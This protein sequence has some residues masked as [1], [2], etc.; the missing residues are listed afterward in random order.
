MVQG[1]AFAFRNLGDFLK[2]LGLWFTLIVEYPHVRKVFSSHR[3]EGYFQY[4]ELP[5]SFK[6]LGDHAATK[7]LLAMRRQPRNSAFTSEMEFIADGPVLPTYLPVEEGAAAALG[8][9]ALAAADPIPGAHR[10]PAEAEGAP[11]GFRLN[12]RVV[13]LHVRRA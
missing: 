8:A 12:D 11:V 2:R 5:K 10:P 7:Q 13:S 1:S 3:R 4:G 6:L 9:A